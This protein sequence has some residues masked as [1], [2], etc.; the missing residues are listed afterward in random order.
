MDGALGQRHAAVSEQ[1]FK[2]GIHYITGSLIWAMSLYNALEWAKRRE[3]HLAVNASLYAALW[4]FEGYQ[5][6][7]HW[8]R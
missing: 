2:G 6:H 4:L 7:R 1:A 5:A 8:Q 3:T